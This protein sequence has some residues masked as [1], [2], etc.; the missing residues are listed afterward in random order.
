M[1]EVRWISVQICSQN[2]YGPGPQDSADRFDDVFSGV[3]VDLL[4][5]G[6]EVLERWS[7]ELVGSEDCSTRSTLG[8]V[9]VTVASQMTIREDGSWLED[10]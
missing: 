3:G 6:D 9:L 5:L 7:V 8:Q 2:G 10:V 1:V 4:E